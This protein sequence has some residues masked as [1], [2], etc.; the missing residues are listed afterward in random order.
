MGAGE[1]EAEDD[2][3]GAPGRDEAEAREDIT[4][5]PGASKE[6][7]SRALGAGKAAEG[8]GETAEIV[9]WVGATG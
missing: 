1:P 9:A 5:L 8:E 3:G 2:T 6:D 4:E 7:A